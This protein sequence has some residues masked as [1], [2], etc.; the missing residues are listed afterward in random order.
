MRFPSVGIG[1]VVIGDEDGVVIHAQI[2]FQSTEEMLGQMERVPL[3]E[4]RTQAFSQLIDERLSD[5]GQ[6]HLPQTNVKIERASTLPT[7]V[8]FEPEKLFDVPALGKIGG[9]G[10]YFRARPGAAEALEMKGLGAFSGALDIT[11]ARFVQGGAPGQVC[12]AGD[13]KTGPVPSECALG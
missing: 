13:G 1:S 10:R 8:L 2:A 6:G 7:Q 11:A 5:Q 4:G 9:Q 3:V 12:F